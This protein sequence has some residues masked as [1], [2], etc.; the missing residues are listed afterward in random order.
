MY[1]KRL[2]LVAMVTCI[3]AYATGLLLDYDFKKR[4]AD[5]W[6]Q[7]TDELL[8]TN[9][10]YDIIFLGNSRMHFGINPF[11][12]DSVTKLNSYNFGTGGADAQEIM[13]ITSIY[14]QKHPTPSLTIIS[15]DPGIL[16]ESEILKTRFQYLFYLNND[17]I[18]QYMSHAGFLTSMI[19]IFPFTKY[20]F[21]DEYHRTSLF[22]KGNPY[23]VFDH[24]IYKGFLNIHQHINSKLP[25]P[26]N[27]DTAAKKLSGT[28]IMYFRKTVTALQQKGSKVILV[29]APLRS[30]ARNKY[31][32][33]KKSSDSLFNHIANEFHLKQFHFENDALYL[34]Q[35]FVDDI[36]LNEPGT[37][38]FSLN[39]ADSIKSI[40]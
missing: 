2:F 38:I 13:M 37:R 21:F 26:F 11:Y 31:S 33:T 20:S 34:D 17:T 30:S 8:K 28:S 24:N 35:F 27:V 9:T 23:P 5:L 7:K 4:W 36:H 22:V 3:L 32:Q 25:N 39:L 16:A 1:L 10:N 19:N 40:Y 14:L 12:I 15:L 18:N 6:F 29:W